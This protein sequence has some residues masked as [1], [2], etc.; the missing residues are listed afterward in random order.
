MAVGL[1]VLLALPFLAWNGL[2]EAADASSYDMLLRLSPRR[3]GAA[4]KQVVLLAVDDN[5]VNRYG[6][7]PL[8][9]AVLASALDSVASA[10][11]SVLVV[12]VL[13]SEH[14]QEKAD[15]SLADALG[16]FPKVVLASALEPGSDATASRWITPLPDFQSRAYA[17]GH[18]HIEPDRDGVARSL[19]LTKAN[20]RSRYWALGFEAFRAAIGAEGSPIEYS[21]RVVV[22]KRSVPAS[23]SSGRL[24]WIN[25]GGPEGTFQRV[26]VASVLEG[27]VPLS[28]FTG[29]VVILGVTAQGAGDRIFT[30]FSA[31]VGMSGIEIHANIF[32]TLLDGAYLSPLGPVSELILLLAIVAAVTAAAWWRKGRSLAAVAIVGIVVIPVFSYWAL[33]AGLIIPVASCLVTHVSASLVC[34][35]GQTRFIRRQL[36]EAVQGRKE[37]AFRLQAVAHEIKTPLT[38][39]HASSQLIT[40]SDVPERKKEEIAQRIFKESGRLSGIVTTFLDVERISAGALQLQRQQ[41]ELA[42]VVSEASERAQL[43]ALKKEITIRKVLETVTVP[44]DSELLEYAIYNLIANAVKYSPNGSSITVSVRSDPRFASVAVADQGCGIEVAEQS[45]I[46]ERFYRANKHREERE[47]GTG[48]GLALVK[49]IV[50]QHGGRIEVD[51]Q[52]GKGS[53]FS[54]FLPRECER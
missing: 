2:V 22:A 51:S 3:Q 54:L 24:L 50:T 47:S 42:A 27:R 4:Q 12:D 40:D 28:A 23:Q 34:F 13:I 35:L 31:G 52:P 25:Y 48:V 14:T 8:N 10:K 21:N 5:T 44:G 49:E 53:R 17:I 7:L 1:L 43:L 26:S 29:K 11:P 19:L 37:Y 16:R 15:A 6:P 36:G 46:F 33:R 30:P 45:R 39:I 20:Q 41:V 9:R 38:A 18:V 32:A